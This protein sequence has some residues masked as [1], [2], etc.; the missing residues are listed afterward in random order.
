MKNREIEHKNKNKRKKC[1]QER[2]NGKK[3]EFLS[4]NRVSDDAEAEDKPDLEEIFEIS[5]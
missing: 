1:G 2:V 5:K 4:L 3:M